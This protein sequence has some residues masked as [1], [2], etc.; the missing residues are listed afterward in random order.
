MFPPAVLIDCI[1]RML[2]Y[3]GAILKASILHA[4]GGTFYCWILTSHLI[5]LYLLLLRII[6]CFPCCDLRR[7]MKQ[8]YLLT[9]PVWFAVMMLV[10]SSSPF[11]GWKLGGVEWVVCVQS[12]MRAFESS[13]MYCTTSKK[14][15]KVLRGLESRVGELHW[16]ALRSRWVTVGTELDLGIWPK[17]Y[18]VIQVMQH[19]CH[20]PTS[21]ELFWLKYYCEKIDCF[22]RVAYVKFKI[23][24]GFWAI[25]FV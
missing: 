23:H 7:D 12:G 8:V 5:K 21:A 20:T 11:S 9:T 14:W 17:M 1:C 2:L 3:T 25:A 19:I 13:G 15:R 10:F 24:S 18:T 6:L 22:Q 4:W 16:R